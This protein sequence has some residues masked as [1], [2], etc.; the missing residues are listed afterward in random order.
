MPPRPGTLNPMRVLLIEDNDHL[1]TSLA[2]GLGTVGYVVESA[3]DGTEGW[4][5]ASEGRH[6]LI[7]LDRMLPH[8][9]GLE[10]LRRLRAAGVQVPVLLLTAKDTTE[11]TVDGLDAGA[12]DYLSKPFA[13]PEL[14]ARLRT[15]GRRGRHRSD[16]VVTITDLEIDTRG[17]VARRG[18]RRL[19]LTVMEFALLDYLAARPGTLVPR[20]ELIGHLY[21][22]VADEEANS[23]SLAMLIARLRRKLHPP[24]S[25]PLLHTRR[26]FGYQLGGEV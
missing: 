17:K 8:L 23:D 7:I 6:D 26:G 1:R 21:G 9:D 19:D 5:L 10:I 18:G 11:D 24:G 25:E 14:L 22:T 16:P 15:L 20:L 3:A 12:D 13:V 2:K 4:R